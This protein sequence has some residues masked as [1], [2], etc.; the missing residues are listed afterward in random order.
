MTQY[1][2]FMLAFAASASAPGPEIAGL[3][4]R[5][6]GNGIRAGVPLASGIVVGKLTLLTA[7]IIGLTGLV[8]ALG[9]LFA[10]LQYAGAAYLIRL[11]VKKWRRA[12]RLLA[13]DAAVM[14]NS[15]LK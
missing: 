12:G 13:P 3:L 8:V 2:V 15:L 9:P 1:V 6:L 5:T 14:P 10:V 11:G 7:A 4:A